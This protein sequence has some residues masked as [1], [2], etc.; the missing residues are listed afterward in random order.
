MS[1]V[2]LLSSCAGLL[3][4]VGTEAC[5]CCSRGIANV[6]MVKQWWS[7]A[8]NAARPWHWYNHG[9][10]R[11]EQESI[12]AC[13]F[14]GCWCSLRREWAPKVRREHKAGHREG[15]DG[16]AEVGTCVSSWAGGYLLGR[17]WVAP[18]PRFS[19]AQKPQYGLHC[20]VCTFASLKSRQG[21]LY[22]GVCLKHAL[23]WHEQCFCG[24]FSSCF[25]LRHPSAD[26]NVFLC[27]P[28][29]VCPS[30]PSYHSPSEKSAVHACLSARALAAFAACQIHV[31]LV[32]MG[33]YR[34][35]GF[36]N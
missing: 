36:F 23:T 7:V 12:G 15:C 25:S 8:A 24:Q 6:S 11:D 26:G 34:Y 14:L 32:G 21:D 16:S 1:E 31:T 19:V 27:V 30:E 5:L 3:V 2:T 17:Q 4:T 13:V 20:G 33:Q 22:L 29:Q 28:Y 10:S 9:N 18:S 35:E